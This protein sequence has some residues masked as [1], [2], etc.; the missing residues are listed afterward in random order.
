MTNNGGSNN[1]TIGHFAFYNYA[2]TSTQVSAHFAAA[3]L[4]VPV[5]EP[6]TLAL[7]A[8]GLAGL[9]AYAWRKRR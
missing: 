5:P 2:L 3:Q 8:A 6:S 4:A 9:L 7:L 1:D